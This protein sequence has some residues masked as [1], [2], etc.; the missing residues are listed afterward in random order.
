MQDMGEQKTV[1]FQ[2]AFVNGH[3]SLVTNTKL[4]KRQG[5]N[6]TFDKCD[7]SYL[8]TDFSY[9]KI[10]A[11]RSFETSKQTHYNICVRPEIK[12]CGLSTLSLT[13]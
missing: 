7:F 9:P 8:H 10:E 2:S 4:L 11:T 12:S 5:K 3:L 1:N 13:T 6:P